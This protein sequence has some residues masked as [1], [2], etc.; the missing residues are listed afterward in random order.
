[1]KSFFMYEYPSN[2]CLNLISKPAGEPVFLV[3]SEHIT[4][5]YNDDRVENAE[6]THVEVTYPRWKFVPQS[7]IN[8]IMAGQI[9]AL[10]E[11][12]K[13]SNAWH[14]KAPNQTQTTRIHPPSRRRRPISIYIYI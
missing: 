6:V 9:L 10:T 5:W 3:F 14:W 12:K 2:F 11:D 13:R 7:S 8:Y 1:M 4:A